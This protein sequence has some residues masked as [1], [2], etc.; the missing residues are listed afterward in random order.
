MK[1]LKDRNQIGSTVIASQLPVDKWYDI[2]ADPTLADAILD[3]IVHN[4]HQIELI[5]DSMRKKQAKQIS[6]KQD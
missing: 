2:L 6:D 4:S 1:S 5:G 3:R